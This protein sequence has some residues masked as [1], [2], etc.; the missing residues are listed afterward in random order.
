M[1]QLVRLAAI[2]CLSSYASIQA[3]ATEVVSSPHWDRVD[4][5]WGCSSFSGCAATPVLGEAKAEKTLVDLKMKEVHLKAEI[6]HAEATVNGLKAKDSAVTSLLQTEE[7]DGDASGCADD[8]AC[9]QAKLN[10]GSSYTCS[11]S[12]QW[13]SSHANDMA[14]CPVSCSTCPA[15]FSYPPTPAPTSASDLLGLNDQEKDTLSSETQSNMASKFSSRVQNNEDLYSEINVKKWTREGDQG[16]DVMPSYGVTHVYE[17]CT[18]KSGYSPVIVNQVSV[19]LYVFVKIACS[20][21]HT[22]YVSRKRIIRGWKF[23]CGELSSQVGTLCTACYTYYHKDS[24]AVISN[25]AWEELE[26]DD[27]D[28]AAAAIQ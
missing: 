17:N 12:T 1:G 20:D 5:S 16:G 13:C 10:W 4:F 11:G 9:L 26:L 25:Y 8:D 28:R 23:E 2:I 21:D 27:A 3:S 24:C 14:C 18:V 22:N 6:Q 7:F 15:G 19:K